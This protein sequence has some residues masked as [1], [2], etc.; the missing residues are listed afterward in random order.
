MSQNN[1]Y[2]YVV[3]HMHVYRGTFDRGKELGS[4]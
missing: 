4:E 3:V 1:N 2:S